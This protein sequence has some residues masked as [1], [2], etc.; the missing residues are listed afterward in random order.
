MG[1][2]K[3]QKKTKKSGVA[4]EELT[5]GEDQAMDKHGAKP[6]CYRENRS[7]SK[8]VGPNSQLTDRI[9]RRLER[10][11]RPSKRRNGRNG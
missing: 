5:E 9:K 3:S 1:K 2:R 10:L 4:N 6:K 8:K 11:P 7:E